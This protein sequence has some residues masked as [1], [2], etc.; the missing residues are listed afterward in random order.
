GAHVGNPFR[1]PGLVGLLGLDPA[2]RQEVADRAR[3]SL[4]PVAR[5]GGRDRGDLIE[6]QMPF[7]QGVGAA[8]KWDRSPVEAVGGGGLRISWLLSTI[9]YTRHTGAE[10]S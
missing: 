6:G 1:M 4:E 9:E 3:D 5:C 8:R 10:S 2:L 7:I